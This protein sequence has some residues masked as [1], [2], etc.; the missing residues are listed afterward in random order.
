MCLYAFVATF[1]YLVNNL[2][3]LAYFHTADLSNKEP[4]K[5]LY[6]YHL[7]AFEDLTFMAPL[8]LRVDRNQCYQFSQCIQKK[9]R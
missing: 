4:A 1:M 8:T 7:S 2:L 5:D 3:I 6:N 9:R